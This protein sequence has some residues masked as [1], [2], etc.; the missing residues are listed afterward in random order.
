MI[1]IIATILAAALMF[2]AAQAQTVVSSNIHNA[3]GWLPSH[4]YT[5]ATG[6]QTRVNSG[7]GWNPATSVYTPGQ[8]LAAYE[9]TSNTCVSAAS[10]GPSGTGTAI[11]DGTCTWKYLSPTDYISITGWSFDAPAWQAGSYNYFSLVTTGAP[12]RTYMLT[13]GAG[14][15]NSTVAPTGNAPNI[16]V[17][18]ADGCHWQWR[19]DVIYSSGVSF[20]PPQTGQNAPTGTSNVF[21]V[22]MVSD[23]KALIWNDREYVAGQ[24]WE[25]NPIRVQYH[26]DYTREGASLTCPAGRCPHINITTAPGESFRDKLAPGD[27][28]TGYDPTKGVAILNT[29]T[30]QWPYTA[31]GLDIH[32]NYVDVFGLQIKSDLGAAIDGANSYANNISIDNSILYGGGTNNV[33]VKTGVSVDALSVISNSLIISGG[34]WGVYFKYP[35]YLINSTV[36]GINSANNQA[37]VHSGWNWIFPAGQT[38]ANTAIQGFPHVASS[39]ASC[40]SGQQCVTWHGFN[41]VTSAPSETGITF[42]AGNSTQYVY[43]LPGTTT[44]NAS[45]M[46]IGAGDY[47]PAG[48]LLGGGANFGAFSVGSKFNV[49][50]YNRDT[51]DILG[52][53]R[54]A[55]GSNV[56]AYQGSGVAPPPTPVNG[57][58]GSANGVAVSVS[59]T[60]NLCLAGTPGAVSGT[61]PWGWPCAG[62]NGGTTAQCS[63]PLATVSVPPPVPTGLVRECQIPLSWGASVGATGYDVMRGGVRVGVTATP[64]YIDNFTE[65]APGSTQ[66]YT[67]DAIGPG[68][69]SALSAPLS[70]RCQ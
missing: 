66:T 33:T 61:G 1:Q 69:T 62:L 5:P 67:V 39:E 17:A 37:G 14:C 18:T 56:G 58:C 63:A 68:G 32:D 22:R 46:F 21:T 47:R 29:T 3:P 43:D 12:L 26:D 49:R 11:Q 53:A 24:N 44:Y 38:V 51:P 10:G 50:T 27:S 45:G 16:I 48:P 42:P 15:A 4:A 40:L 34:T 41:T 52:V 31:A 23:Y 28:L 8:P 36:V 6:P 30:N 19:G 70:A 20:I 54:P 35:G 2:G 9:L 55:S 65:T 7:P 13:D 59:P 25:T 60:N 64:N 57:A